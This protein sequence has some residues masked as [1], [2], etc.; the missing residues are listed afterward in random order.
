MRVVSCSSNVAIHTAQ[1]VH[2]LGGRADEYV[3]D[4]A[5][6]DRRDHF[7]P[8]AAGRGRAVRC[9]DSVHT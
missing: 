9:R 7:L 3:L 4:E 8:W 6:I 5:I 1:K 2:Q